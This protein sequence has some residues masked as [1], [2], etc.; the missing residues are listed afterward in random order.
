ME[1]RAAGRRRRPTRRPEATAYAGGRSAAVREPDPG[2][3]GGTRARGRLLKVYA[4]SHAETRGGYQALLTLPRTI[5]GDPER[6]RGCEYRARG[7]ANQQAPRG[8]SAGSRR[9]T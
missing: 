7:P 3:P 8:E 1:G 6:R 5:R 2:A 9:S 4:S